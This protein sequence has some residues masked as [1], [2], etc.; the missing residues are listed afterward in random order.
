MSNS[1]ETT[2]GLL[3]PNA[4]SPTLRQS[5]DNWLLASADAWK[6]SRAWMMAILVAPVF[7]AATGV[8][9]SLAGKQI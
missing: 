2:R 8:V 4:S 3:R 9:A 1:T 6:I 5:F 7:L